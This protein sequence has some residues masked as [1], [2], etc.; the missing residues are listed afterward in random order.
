ML[1]SDGTDGQASGAI[2]GHQLSHGQGRSF[3]HHGDGNLPQD[4][5]GGAEQAAEE[6]A[7]HVGGRERRPPNH[8]S[9]APSNGPN[10]FGPLQYKLKEG[11][12]HGPLRRS[13]GEA[14]GSV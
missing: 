1:F 5:G 10:V 11:R 7:D 8:N 4:A 2:Q 3:D 13:L 14:T 6:R 12:G 9:S